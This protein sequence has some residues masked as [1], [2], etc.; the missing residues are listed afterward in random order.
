MGNESNR[1]GKR[2]KEKSEQNRIMYRMNKYNLDTFQWTYYYLISL[3]I[4]IPILEFSFSRHSQLEFNHLESHF[5]TK[6]K[7]SPDSGL[8]L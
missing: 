4:Q 8:A 6:F 5:N 1:K 2:K 3:E 7:F